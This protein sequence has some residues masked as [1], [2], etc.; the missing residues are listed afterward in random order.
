VSFRVGG[1]EDEARERLREVFSRA[2]CDGFLHVCD[3]DGPREVA[4]DADVTVV[5]ASTFKV[6]VA[7]ELFR[8]AA[9]GELDPAERVRLSPVEGTFGPT[10]FSLFSDEVEVS[11]RDLAASMLAVSDNA[12][13]DVLIGRLGLDRINGLTRSLGLTETVIV[14]DVRSMVDSLAH[15][16]GFASWAEFAAT[17]WNEVDPATIAATLERMRS[18]RA[19]DPTQ[20]SRTTPR[21][22]TQL[23]CAIWRDEAAPSAA[24]AQVRALMAKQLTRHRIARGF[25]SEAEISAKSGSFGGAIRNEIGVVE[26]PG[27]GRY[28]VAVFTRAHELYEREHEINDAIGTA[29]RIAVDAVSARP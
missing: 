3:V 13:T 12:A 29:S 2:G 8:R 26:L 5:A 10:G 6:A 7:L 9:E 16:A 18:A 1:V 14:G 17:A 19:V 23:L 27:A 20:A 21:E 25:G 28:A 22:T 4:L 24:C 11:L 15:D